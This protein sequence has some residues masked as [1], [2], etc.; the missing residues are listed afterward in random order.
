MPSQILTT[1]DLREF[2]V[3]LIIEI[4]KLLSQNGIQPAKHFSLFRFFFCQKRNENRNLT[5]I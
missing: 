2:K 1:D 4:Q 3:E 5:A